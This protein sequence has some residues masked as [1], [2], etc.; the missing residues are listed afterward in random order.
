MANDLLFFV[1]RDSTGDDTLWASDGSADGTRIVELSPD[2]ASLTAM[3]DLIE[4]NG[5]LYFVA[6]SADG[7]Q[8]WKTFGN[9]HD[10]QQVTHVLPGSGAVRTNLTVA[11]GRL[12]FRSFD[13][14]AGYEP[15]STDGTPAGP[16]L[17]GDFNT[18][19][20]PSNPSDY[21]GIGDH[22]YF[23]ATDAEHGR[24]LWKSDGTA[25]GTTV[26][27][28]LPSY[29]GD[30]GHGPRELWGIDGRVYFTAIDDE[31]NF[32]FWESDGTPQGT[33]PVTHFN[34]P[35]LSFEFV[36]LQNGFP[37]RPFAAG[38]ALYFVAHPDEFSYGNA[39]WKIDDSPM[40]ASLVRDFPSSDNHGPW[41]LTGVG[42]KLYF[43]CA[44]R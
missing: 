22:V 36:P 17:L 32:Q 6:N 16:Q 29:Y 37:T 24:A 42:D 12:Y 34:Y 2:P 4:F 28:E 23:F 14:L 1:L 38:E 44:R 41:H 11:G 20:L 15:F 40:G 5:A 8:L 39:L 7:S 30:S 19:P 27:F 33:Q 13:P 43:S 3:R 9:D 10:A 35:A 31:G 21:V 18:R 26:V 25:E